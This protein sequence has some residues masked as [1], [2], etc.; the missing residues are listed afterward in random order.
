MSFQNESRLIQKA[1][2][3]CQEGSDRAVEAYSLSHVCVEWVTSGGGR[4]GRGE[5]LEAEEKDENAGDG[6]E[7]ARALSK[8]FS[9]VG[10]LKSRGE[11]ATVLVV[12]LRLRG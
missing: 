5:G 2:F 9:G 3:L 4:S 6:I 1:Q 10:P 12:A 7:R 11:G 8:D